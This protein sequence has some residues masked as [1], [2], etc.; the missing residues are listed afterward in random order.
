MRLRGGQWAWTTALVLGL[1]AAG[2]R[3]PGAASR[4]AGTLA[5]GLATNAPPFAFR[6]GWR[7]WTGLD[8]DLGR[9]LAEKL[10]MRPRFVPLKPDEAIPALLDGRVDVLMGGL[11]VTDERRTQIEFSSPYLVTGLGFLIR[12]TDRPRYT[13]AVRIQAMPTRVAVIAHSPAEDLLARYFPRARPFPVPDLQTGAEALRRSRVDLV[14]GEAPALWWLA[15]TLPRG[16]AMAPPLFAR[17]EIA[18]GF[19]QGSMRLRRDANDTLAEW[20]RDGSLESI[21][22][23]WVPVSP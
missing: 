18:W 9:A 22:R 16:M 6:K 8:V 1:A 2:C 5:I 17:R 7:T 13:T 10:N 11:A 19:R 3:S 4:P 23:R 20:T 14:A 12:E 15:R 21:L